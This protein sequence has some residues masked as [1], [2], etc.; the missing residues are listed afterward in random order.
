IV[1]TSWNT[2]GK[3][4]GQATVAGRT[5]ETVVATDS[6]FWLVYD[7]K[8]LRID[9]AAQPIGEPV[10]AIPPD[11]TPAEFAAAGP[12]LLTFFSRQVTTSR[13]TTL[14]LRGFFTVVVPPKARAVRH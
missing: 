8:A 10:V 9:S 11:A 5:I 12:A 4:I 1:V 2:A 7:S 3:T 6:F 13:A 14:V